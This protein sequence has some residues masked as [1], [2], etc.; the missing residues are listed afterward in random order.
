MFLFA[1]RLKP[2]PDTMRPNFGIR[3]SRW[4]TARPSA[5]PG[6]RQYALDPPQLLGIEAQVV[7]RGHALL[8]LLDPAGADQGAG[9]GFGAQRPGQG[10][11]RQA[12][13]A[14][15]ATWPS[16]RTLATRSSVTSLRFRNV[17]GLEAREP[18]GTPSR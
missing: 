5:L 4:P 14:L 2:C 3:P 10:Q 6:L 12:L 7:L 13:A 8:D 17:P 11:L 1:A 18:D 15:R 16:A 9:H